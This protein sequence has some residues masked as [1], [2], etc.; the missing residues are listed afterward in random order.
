MGEAERDG[1]GG[2]DGD[3]PLD[4]VLLALA[5]N[6]QDGDVTPALFHLARDIVLVDET[7][8]TAVFVMAVGVSRCVVLP[9]C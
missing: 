3:P 1:D 7:F 5:V 6:H 4:V 2:Q 8:T 9:S